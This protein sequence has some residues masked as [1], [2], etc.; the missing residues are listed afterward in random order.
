M[1]LTLKRQKFQNLFLLS[2]HNTIRYKK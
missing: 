1:S 2:A